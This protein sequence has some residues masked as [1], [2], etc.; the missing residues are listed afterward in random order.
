LKR[1]DATTRRATHA[2]LYAELGRIY[3]ELTKVSLQMITLMAFLIIRI[4]ITKIPGSKIFLSIASRKMVTPGGL[5]V[6]IPGMQK[7][8]A[9]SMEISLRSIMTA[10]ESWVS[11][12]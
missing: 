9:S 12:R 7:S 5:C 11:P 8:G 4:T 2:A 10:A 3:R 1:F 6:F